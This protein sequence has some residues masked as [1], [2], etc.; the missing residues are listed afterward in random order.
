MAKTLHFM[1]G[2]TLTV[3]LIFTS[4]VPN[5]YY[6]ASKNM[7]ERLQKD[8]VEAQNRLNDCNSQ[9]LKLKKDK[10]NLQYV[11]DSLQGEMKD[12]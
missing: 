1:A 2:I 8:S 6:Y 5:R 9:V 12:L 7:A 4:C 10:I 3:A 11:N